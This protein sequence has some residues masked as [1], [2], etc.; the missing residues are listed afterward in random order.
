MLVGYCFFDDD[1]Y[2]NCIGFFKVGCIGAEMVRK[3]FSF[4][5]VYE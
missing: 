1:N 2:V 3:A 4:F 5:I